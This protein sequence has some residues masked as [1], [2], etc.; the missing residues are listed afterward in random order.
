MRRLSPTTSTPFTL[1][2]AP[3]V[4]VQ[5]GVVT[6]DVFQRIRDELGNLV[7]LL[8]ASPPPPTRR[9]PHV[10]SLQVDGYTARYSVDAERRAVVLLDVVRE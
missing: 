8:S 3:A 10:F 5:L 7:S 6:S 9:T 2:I 1:H 4:W